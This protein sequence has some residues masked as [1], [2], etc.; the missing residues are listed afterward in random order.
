MNNPSRPIPARPAPPGA[1]PYIPEP[2][3]KTEEIPVE[4]KAELAPKHQAISYLNGGG[5][6]GGLIFVAFI[7]AAG[8]GAVAAYGYLTQGMP[9]LA[10]GLVCLVVAVGVSFLLSTIPGRI[11]DSLIYSAAG[12]LF[13]SHG[14]QDHQQAARFLHRYLFTGAVPFLIIREG[15]IDDRTRDSVMAKWDYRGP[16][17]LRIDHVSAVLVEREG[18][19]RVLTLGSHY[20][21]TRD[22]IRGLFDLR[23]RRARLQLQSVLTRDDIPLHITVTIQFRIMQRHEITA[24]QSRLLPDDRAVRRAVFAA[25]DW[26][27]QIETTAR[28][29]VR[30]TIAR[31]YLNDIQ[32]TYYPQFVTAQVQEMVQPGAPGADGESSIDDSSSGAVLPD[33]SARFDADL[34]SD[35]SGQETTRRPLSDVLRSRLNRAVAQWG[36]EVVGVT[37]EEIT[38]PEEVKKT[39]RDAW[40]AHWSNIVKLEAAD[41]SA[42][43]EQRLAEGSR[44][45]AKIKKQAAIVEAEGFVESN[46]IRAT[47]AAETQ[48][49]LTRLL[50]AINKSTGRQMDES[51]LLDIMRGYGFPVGST[52][53]TPEKK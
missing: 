36:A 14:L 18:I 39:L 31:Y 7:F 2:D 19:Q 29:T 27:S 9:L 13:A 4:E 10:I 47:A 8:G 53:P 40:A 16:G 50:A 25:P 21:D 23:L 6:I 37:I 30:E 38:L 3:Y 32:G 49:D 15:R 24:Q 17:Y 20:L 51:L 26:E 5:L 46:R 34:P 42:K 43:V 48:V 52:S 1:R 44:E 35:T 22:W 33:S 28:G 11:V 12:V 41:A 45:A